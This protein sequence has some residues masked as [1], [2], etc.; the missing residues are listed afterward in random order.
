MSS[1]EK[2]LA[3]TPTFWCVARLY[4]ALL[5]LKQNSF[6]FLSSFSNFLDVFCVFSCFVLPFDVI[7]FVILLS[8]CDF[9]LLCLKQNSL[10][11]LFVSVFLFPIFLPH[12]RCES[13][14]LILSFLLFGSCVSSAA[15]PQPLAGLI[16]FFALHNVC[17]ILL[18]SVSQLDIEL[19][20]RA[21]KK[22]KFT[23]AI[24]KLPEP[25]KNAVY[26][27]GKLF[28]FLFVSLS[29][30]LS[31]VDAVLERQCEQLRSERDV[32]KSSAKYQLSKFQYQLERSQY[33]M[34]AISMYQR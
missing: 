16:F 20:A 14:F 21:F 13:C 12:F 17:L 23:E 8:C 33:L 11:F 6:L 10:S 28:R 29:M 18:F 4:F 24:G 32:S 15:Q 7:L 5:F 31:F 34:D 26:L 1:C 2:C 3:P 25:D 9:A 27:R 22:R 19:E 30:R